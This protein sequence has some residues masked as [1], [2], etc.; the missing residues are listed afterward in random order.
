L[1]LNTL[2][3]ALRQA[4][5]LGGLCSERA[6]LGALGSIRPTAFKRL[7]ERGRHPDFKRVKSGFEPLGVRIDDRLLI[8]RKEDVAIVANGL[9]NMLGV[10]WFET[11][12]L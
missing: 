2:A 11:M 12:L 5:E 3:R 8:A 7:K 10:L 9:R 1:T 6:C 4:R